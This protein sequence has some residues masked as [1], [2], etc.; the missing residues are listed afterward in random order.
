MPSSVKVGGHPDVGDRQVRVVAGH[1]VEQLRRRPT[2]AR[3]R[4]AV[5]QQLDQ[6]RPAAAPS[7]RRSRFA[8]NSTMTSSG[9]RAGCRC[10][11]RPPR[12]PAGEPPSPEQP[13]GPPAPAPGAAPPPPSSVT[14]TSTLRSARR[15]LGPGG[16]C[17]LGHV[18]QGLG[19]DEV[20][21]RLDVGERG[22]VGDQS[23]P[24]A[25]RAPRYRTAPR[26][27]P[28]RPGRRMQA[29]DRS[30][31]SDSAS[32]PPWASTMTCRT[33][34]GIPVSARARGPGSSPARPAAAG[35]RHAGHARSGGARHRSRRRRRRGCGP[36]NS[37]RC[38]SSSARLGPRSR[39]AAASSAEV[40]HRAS[41]GAARSSAAAVTAA[42]RPAAAGGC[43]LAAQA[44]A[45]TGADQQASTS[46]P[47]RPPMTTA[48]RWNPSCRRRGRA[49]GADRPRPACRLLGDRPDVSPERRAQAGPLQLAE[50]P[51]G[52]QHRHRD[53][54]GHDRVEHGQ[55]QPPV[56]PAARLQIAAPQRMTSAP[57]TASP[58]IAAG[59]AASAF[60]VARRVPAGRRALSTARTGPVPGESADAMTSRYA[61]SAPRAIPADP[62][63]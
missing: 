59:Q 25:A 10:R 49:P 28:G 32:R 34:S 53:D 12:R 13:T 29:A 44:T 58:V 36:A 31:S 7:P 22:P 42:A 33:G 2:A 30:R 52:P 11:C 38:A 45:T 47:P 43:E 9:R 48:S 18:G 39:R 1:G 57:I 40:T 17:V 19:H 60:S 50:S 55:L 3:P 51:H 15:H 4:S 6:A 16:V 61:A 23:R 5:L 35:R 46:T 37:T 24:A 27:G 26:P 20:R 21:D 62:P 56:G 8:W 54:H 14:V 63:A 41:Q